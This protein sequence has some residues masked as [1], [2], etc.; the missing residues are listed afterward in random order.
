MFLTVTPSENAVLYT[1]GHSYVINKTKI[2]ENIKQVAVFLSKL[3]K[4]GL[5]SS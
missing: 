1:N 2:T 3:K 4:M 5:G